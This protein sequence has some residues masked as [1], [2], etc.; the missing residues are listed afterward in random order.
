MDLALQAT[1]EI[2][3]DDEAIAVNSSYKFANAALESFNDSVN[4]RFLKLNK[5]KTKS[6]SSMS[7]G[8]VSEDY[9]KSKKQCTIV[10]GEGTYSE[11]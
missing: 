4:D 5:P 11:D 9:A 10:V 7:E 6:A 8:I 2:T 3:R 1:A